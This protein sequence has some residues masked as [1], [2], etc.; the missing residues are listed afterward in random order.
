MKIL[1][2]ST[3]GNSSAS[4]VID[5]VVVAAIEEERLTRLKNDGGFPYRS[6]EH[7]L[8]VSGLDISDIDI[9]SVY[10]RPWRIL[11]RIIGTSKLAFLNYYYFKIFINL[12]LNSFFGINKNDK[13]YPELRG[14]W[15][16]LFRLKSLLERKFGKFSAKIEFID[17]HMSHIASSYFISDFKKA[18]CLSYDGGGEDISTAIYLIDN[19]KFQLVKSFKWPNS[20]GHFYSA[21]TGFLGFRMLEGEYKMMGLAPYGS[22]KYKDIILEK[23]LIKKAN[24][25]YSLNT[26]ILNYHMALSGKFTKKLTKI[27][28]QPR[29]ASEEFTD[30]HMDIASSVQSAFEEVLLHI[31]TWINKKYPEYENLCLSGGCALNVTA[32]G[33]VIDKSIFKNIFIPPGPHDGGCAI[34]SAFISELASP[35]NIK[36]FKMSTPY[37]GRSYSNEEILN[38]FMKLNYPLP[39]FLNE[40]DLIK[41]TVEALQNKQIIAWFQG[42]SEFGPRALGNRS[43]LADPRNDDIRELINEKIKKRELFRPFAPSCKSE[44]QMN[45]FKIKQSSPYMNIVSE[46]IENKVGIIPAVTHID[47]TAR[48]HTV[49]SGTN[50]RYWKLI[51]EFEK[52]TGVGVLLN[53]SFNIQEPI[54]ESPEDAINCY[55]RSKVDL[56]VIGN[57]VCDSNWRDNVKKRETFK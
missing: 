3:M 36:S 30:Y 39:K 52:K 20:L 25:S 6:I 46:V 2:L 57:Y 1:G 49:H 47:K 34:G 11:T 10:W 16:D 27:F 28:G 31:I 12:I 33:K 32:N 29:E 54:V 55:L 9:V 53:T 51:D 4:I 48:V 8:E 41:T 56:L 44:S 24:G 26:S 45:Y 13:K 7:C 21:F 23:I 42:G 38:Y 14:S 19:S 22:P 17:H 40:E 18:A 50:Y 5:G 15:L 37:L 43:F 35:T